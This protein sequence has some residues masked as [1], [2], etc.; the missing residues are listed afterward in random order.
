[1]A[2]DYLQRGHG[3]KSKRPTEIQWSHCFDGVTTITFLYSYNILF[4]PLHMGQ[5]QIVRQE[6]R[7]LVH[8]HVAPIS[9][10]D[11]SVVAYLPEEHLWVTESFYSHRMSRSKTLLFCTLQY[12]YVILS[13]GCLYSWHLINW[14]LANSNLTVTQTKVIFP[15]IYFIHSL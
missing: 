8:S 9:S 15:S 6:A 11:G 10:T 5:Y 12:R 7:V 2:V 1:M 4:F 13:L 3:L 14:T